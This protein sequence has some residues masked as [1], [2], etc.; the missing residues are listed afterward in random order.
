MMNNQET[1]GLDE[2]EASSD[3]ECHDFVDDEEVDPELIQ[4]A[5]AAIERLQRHPADHA[6]VMLLAEA[7][8][9]FPPSSSA[10]I[11]VG[12]ALAAAPA[13]CKAI[14]DAAAS[15]QLP[16]RMRAVNLLLEL[17]TRLSVSPQDVVPSTCLPSFISA[18]HSGTASQ[19][20]VCSFLG[21]TLRECPPFAFSLISHPAPLLNLL[22]E[23]CV[24]PM[25]ICD[26]LLPCE[27][28]E[29]SSHSPQTRAFSAVSELIAGLSLWCRSKKKSKRMRTASPMPSAD[30]FLIVH[31]EIAARIM[32]LLNPMQDLQVL[33]CAV[34]L[35]NE[36][37]ENMPVASPSPLLSEPIALAFF[38]MADSRLNVTHDDNECQKEPK[39]PEE[40]HEESWHN[41]NAEQEM[42][43][44][45]TSACKFLEQSLLEV[46][47][48]FMLLNRFTS[49]FID[50]SIVDDEGN[51]QML[52]LRLHAVHLLFRRFE[53][54][55]LSA[56]QAQTIVQ[57]AMSMLSRP[58]FRGVHTCLMALQAVTHASA[59][60]C[61]TAVSALALIP[62]VLRRLFAVLRNTEWQSSKHDPQEKK[63]AIGQLL[64]SLVRHL[65]ASPQLEKD[66]TE[67]RFLVLLNPDRGVDPESAQLII[68]AA[69]GKSA[70]LQTRARA[71]TIPS[72][73][74]THHFRHAFVAADALP[75][76]FTVG[77]FSPSQPSDPTSTADMLFGDLAS[78]LAGSRQQ[79][80]SRWCSRHLPNRQQGGTVLFHNVDFRVPAMCG[81]WR[82]ARLYPGD[83]GEGLLPNECTVAKRPCTPCGM[84]FWHTKWVGQDEI[85]VAALLRQMADADMALVSYT[86]PMAPCYDQGARE[87]G[88]YSW[89]NLSVKRNPVDAADNALMNYMGSMFNWAVTFFFVSAAGWAEQLGD[90]TARATDLPF[91]RETEE[92]RRE[93]E[94][95][96]ELL[97]INRIRRREL[98]DDADWVESADSQEEDGEDEG[99]SD[100][101]FAELQAEANQPL[102]ELLDDT[103]RLQASSSQTHENGV[104]I[105]Q[106]LDEIYDDGKHVQ[107]PSESPPSPTLPPPDMLEALSQHFEEIADEPMQPFKHFLNAFTVPSGT[108]GALAVLPS[109]EYLWVKL[110][111]HQDPSSGEHLGLRAILMATYDSPDSLLECFVEHTPVGLQ[112]APDGSSQTTLS[113]QNR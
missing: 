104:S 86:E 75:L 43:S 1:F 19:L 25:V 22:L 26:D 112:H 5:L 71:V 83:P 80:P 67:A 56:T 109:Q 73:S 4:T 92:D 102:D 79:T 108:A 27:F 87:V 16:T 94:A 49:C 70:L 58:G 31:R 90:P 101:D 68:E 63:Q 12:Q 9:M 106:Q 8:V 69:A 54:H 3:G 96:R 15:S 28:Q 72:A 23:W 35:I 14:S 62:S 55:E 76:S 17:V 20:G 66:L 36:A 88:R 50:P 45:L 84:V 38:A 52:I 33:L 95:E 110:F 39:G 107:I 64:L 10:G 2:F 30:P 48:T 113:Q 91:L 11:S 32:Q 24:T 37:L 42:L 111:F 41:Q 99:C 60:T 46:A 77:P 61:E 105:L 97:K 59:P 51:S 29:D 18:M 6:D 100:V 13:A 78:V 98:E 89:R 74:T 21:I 82:S 7:V 81:H 93:Y 65:D 57:V 53:L 103:L 40:D 34:R 85:D 47:P 44:D